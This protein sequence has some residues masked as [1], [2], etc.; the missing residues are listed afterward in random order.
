MICGFPWLDRASDALDDGL[1]RFLDAGEPPIVFTLGSA[2]V[3]HPGD[4][5]SL[6]AEVCRQLGRRGVLLTGGSAPEPGLLP[7]SVIARAWA[8]H[9]KLFPRALV[10]VHHAG[11]GTTAQCVRAG[12]PSV[13][14]PHA[15]D[16][17][18]NA[19]RVHA[20]GTG[21]VVPRWHLTRDRLVAALEQAIQ[22]EVMAERARAL[23]AR[24]QVNGADAAA[25]AIER[26]AAAPNEKRSA[27]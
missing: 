19:L 18:N 24:I 13:A 15:F 21:L 10:N 4:F 16:Q 6:A 3:H 20:L 9:V 25:A 2:A 7:A 22:Y 17:F 23:A 27:A 14:V 26:L 11:I 12:R 5:Y 1:A 8:P